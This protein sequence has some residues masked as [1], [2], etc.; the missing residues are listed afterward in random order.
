VRGPFDAVFCLGNA[1]PHLLTDN[2][3][4]RALGN[5]HAVLRPGGMLFLQLLNY[6]RIMSSR[7]RVQS[8]RESGNAT[9]VRMYDY[10]LAGDLI[11]FNLLRLEKQGG[12]A[13]QSHITVP[14]RPLR[15]AELT[16]I[17][18]RSG[19]RDTRLFGGI[20]MDAYDASSSRDLVMMSLREA[21]VNIPP[22]T[23]TKEHA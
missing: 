12:D 19:F 7:T 3:L 4:L 8:V 17:L 10:G 20:S 1:L 5:F 18:H 14:L 22:P 6:D 11:L 21:E 16:A 15:S 13:G 2:D 23:L 9:Y